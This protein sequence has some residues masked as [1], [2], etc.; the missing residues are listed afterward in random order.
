MEM[1][2]SAQTLG[3]GSVL[4][5]TVT[6]AAAFTLPGGYVAD[7]HAR[8]GTPTLAGSYAFDA[9]VM[10]ITLAFA[11][12]LLATFSLMY[13]GVPLV[14]LPVRHQYFLRSRMLA[15]SSVRS[16][17]AAFALGVYVV[18]GPVARMTAIFVCLISSAT[19]LY[20]LR[21][22]W[23]LLTNAPTLY[24]RRGARGFWALRKGIF[25]LHLV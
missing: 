17:A 23:M 24:V 12:S 5:T 2:N 15:V 25:F 7:D 21:E 8:R 19:L 20:G 9:F 16:L 1:T 10:S 4:I 18:L 22:V 3:I 6:F 11:C 14:D 13:S